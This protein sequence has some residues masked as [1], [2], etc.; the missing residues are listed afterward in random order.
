VFQVNFKTPTGGLFN[1]YATNGGEL[2]EL[3]DAF[4]GFI[5]KIAAVEGLIVGASNA[6]PVVA[7]P[8]QQAAPPAAPPNSAPA[9]AEVLCEHGEPAKLIPAGV[10]KASGKPYRAFYACN[11]GREGQ[12]NFRLTA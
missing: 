2:E 9:S 10:S 8:T 6:A 7:R 4:E 12:C 3:L 1:I 11:R 5:P